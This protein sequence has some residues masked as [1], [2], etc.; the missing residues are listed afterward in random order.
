[1]G[2]PDLK[3]KKLH[4]SVDDSHGGSQE[5]ETGIHEKLNSECLREEELA[6]RLRMEEYQVL[7]LV[8]Y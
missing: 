1:M 8:G 5:L 2:S 3:K 7:S 4:A 6:Y